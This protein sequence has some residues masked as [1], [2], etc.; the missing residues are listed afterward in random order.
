MRPEEL[1]H[2]SEY[3]RLGNVYLRQQLDALNAPQGKK[4]LRKLTLLTVRC[5]RCGDRPFVVVMT[6]PHWVVTMFDNNPSEAPSPR[7]PASVVQ[8]GVR[9]VQEW[10]RLSRGSSR[11]LTR[12]E[13]KTFVPIT[14]G[15]R[16]EDSALHSACRC[17]SHMIDRAWL[18][19]HIDG[20]RAGGAREVTV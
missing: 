2:D 20:A 1:D 15:D 4:L 7:P 16:S 6:K 5:R 3:T 13:V 19:E 18:W 8:G 9:A 14:E 12:R 10:Y 11:S 17:R